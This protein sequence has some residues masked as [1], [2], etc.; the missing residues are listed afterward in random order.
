MVSHLD[1]EMESHFQSVTELRSEFDL[2]FE[3][4]FG[5]ASGLV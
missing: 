3:K 2:V 4:A 5:L 1:F